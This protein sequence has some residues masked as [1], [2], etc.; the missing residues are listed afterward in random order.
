MWH[1]CRQF[2]SDLITLGCGIVG[3]CHIFGGC[4]PNTALIMTNI[5]LIQCV[6]GC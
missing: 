5:A 4:H 6:S 1:S 2:D 3:G